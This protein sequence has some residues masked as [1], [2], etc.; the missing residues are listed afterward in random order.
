MEKLDAFRFAALPVHKKIIRSIGETFN[1]VRSIITSF[2]L[3][4]VFR[5]GGFIAFS[6]PLT[7]LK[8]IPDMIRSFGSEKSFE[9][10]QQLRDPAV[11][12][13]SDRASIQ[14]S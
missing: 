8:A 14:S 10:S 6:R 7:A 1:A 9:R 12:G 13:S 3:S 11:G 2:D 4:A 5:Q